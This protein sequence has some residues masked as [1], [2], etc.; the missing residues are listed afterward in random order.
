MA[1]CFVA[2]RPNSL[3]SHA[4][5][6]LNGAIWE[7]V[8]GIASIIHVS[9]PRSSLIFELLEALGAGVEDVAFRARQHLRFL[10]VV[11]DLP[12]EVGHA[13]AEIAPWHAVGNLV[14]L[15]LGFRFLNRWRIGWRDALESPHGVGEYVVRFG[16]FLGGLFV[17]GHGRGLNQPKNKLSGVIP[18]RRGVLGGFDL[19]DEGDGVVLDVGGVLGDLNGGRHGDSDFQFGRRAILDGGDVSVEQDGRVS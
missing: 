6:F 7:N 15:R 5:S 18:R 11:P 10:A 13:R 4:L 14:F 1:D 12:D 8:N 2:F 17:E 16:R 19:L 3:E 9:T